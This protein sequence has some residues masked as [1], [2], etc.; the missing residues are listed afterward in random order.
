MR[1]AIAVILLLCAVL[2]VWMLI[3]SDTTIPNQEV[4]STSH[5]VPYRM[6]PS[7][8]TETQ[9]EEAEMPVP[10]AEVPVHTAEIAPPTE[11]R[12]AGASIQGYLFSED[13]TIDVGD[14]TLTIETLN[15]G[16]MQDQ[17]SPFSKSTRSDDDGGFV[18]EHL[19][20]DVYRIQLED[21]ELAFAPDVTVVQNLSQDQ[22]TITGLALEVVTSGAI[23][24]RV[25]NKDTGEALP[26]IHVGA[27]MQLTAM[28]KRTEIYTSG[29]SDADGNYRID[30]IPAGLYR[31]FDIELPSPEIPIYIAAMQNVSVYL[32]GD[33][34]IQTNMNIRN[35][36][37]PKIYTEVKAGEISEEIDVS[38][39]VFPTAVIS[40]VVLFP[41]N[42]P[43][44][45]VQINAMRIEAQEQA[46]H[47]W[48]NASQESSMM[49]SIPQ[50]AISDE[51]GHFH[52]ESIVVGYPYQLLLR[53]ENSQL[54]YLTEEVSEAGIHGLELVMERKGGISGVV[55][56]LD[57]KVIPYLILHLTD[58]RLTIN[59]L[60][61]YSAIA[62]YARSDEEGKFAFQLLKPGEYYIYVTSQSAG[63]LPKAEIANITLQDG[64]VI[65]DLELVYKPQV[66]SI[67]GRVITSDG[68]PVAYAHITAS[69]EEDDRSQKIT[70]TSSAEGEFLIFP[71]E[72]QPYRVMARKE[73]Y[74]IGEMANVQPG[75]QVEIVL[76]EGLTL[77]GQVLCDRTG[78]P[79]KHYGLSARSLH[80]L[81]SSHEVQAMR[82]DVKQNPEIRYKTHLPLTSADG[83]GQHHPEGRFEI[84]GVGEN[85][86]LHVHSIEGYNGHKE[87]IENITPAIAAR[88]IIIHLKEADIIAGVVQ[89]RHLRP[90]VD[91]V[92]RFGNPNYPSRAG[93]P[94]WGPGSAGV[95]TNVEGHFTLQPHREEIIMGVVVSHEDYL[96]V[97]V[98]LP[99]SSQAQR[100]LVITLKEGGRVEGRITQY[101]Q[102]LEGV[103]VSYQVGEPVSVS[104][105]VEPVLTDATGYYEIQNLPD[106]SVIVQIQEPSISEGTIRR[107]REPYSV[108][109]EVQS[110]HV[111]VVDFD[112][113]FE[114][115]EIHGYVRLDDGNVPFFANVF[116][117]I[118][119]EDAGGKR[120]RSFS[121]E[122]EADG[123]YYLDMLP[124]GHVQL[125]V[126]AQANA[127][128]SMGDLDTDVRQ[129]LRPHLN[130]SDGFS[131][132]P[133]GRVQRDFVL[134][135][136]NEFQFQI[137]RSKP[138]GAN[139][140]ILTFRGQ[141]NSTDIASL[142][143]LPDH[144]EIVAHNTYPGLVVHDLQPGTYTA[145]LF[146]VN[147]EAILQ[148]H[149]LQLEG[150]IVPELLGTSFFSISDNQRVGN[151]EIPLRF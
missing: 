109:V 100:N 123:S 128:V 119:P 110:G 143:D 67:Q 77:F 50:Y 97:G 112:I 12:S 82:E 124:G 125:H 145:A 5:E 70:T 63:N 142:A 120:G 126:S 121:T 34:A 57:G 122:I 113:P 146:E 41:D 136:S 32:M 141:V 107:H 96:P 105:H 9:Q 4:D 149:E 31:V 99:D 79:I 21:P 101:G 133:G 83:L 26:G 135:R 37:F 68:E 64:E 80:D 72:Q 88:E 132:P 148:H 108:E 134:E 129:H 16:F 33:A 58:T 59:D 13:P 147:Y 18:F 144:V 17:V 90:I 150:P 24:G 151:Y 94:G 43:A 2:F 46:V 84:S 111:K 20:Y 65:D 85:I 51:E 3:S 86:L 6:Q 78:E 140:M 40:G 130:A 73:P 89:D 11:V 98:P 56:S 8:S 60:L 139:W 69:V 36:E 137:S 87:I 14:R 116:A 138:E 91:A 42:S 115:A 30:G 81:R 92:V 71:E 55:R 49:R 61:E 7:M 10:A 48:P 103:S 22:G 54:D 131:L 106:G 47:G 44:A 15:P 114:N 117:Y 66:N 74:A 53:K 62:G 95:Y 27:V 1:Y 45:Q 118:Q 29:R 76:N 39:E 35:G 23:T 38:V 93:S 25:Y 75:Q 127:P 102:P 28:P 104:H 19:T 52:L